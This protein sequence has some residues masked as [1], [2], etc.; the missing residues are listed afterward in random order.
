MIQGVALDILDPIDGSY[1]ITLV[2]DVD[3]NRYKYC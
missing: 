2:A 3:L 1:I